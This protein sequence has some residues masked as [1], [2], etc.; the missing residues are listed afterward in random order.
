M[1]TPWLIFKIVSESIQKKCQSNNKKN[2]L[3]SKMLI[4]EE[5]TG[6]NSSGFSGI[7]HSA[8]HNTNL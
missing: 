7:D 8:N 6:G 1:K 2:T 3:A 5:W 4:R